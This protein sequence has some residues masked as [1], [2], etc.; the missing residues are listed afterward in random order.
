MCAHL[1]I[2]ETVVVVTTLESGI[3]R[4]FACLDTPEEGFERP[5]YPQDHILQDLSVDRS[6]VLPQL[7]YIWQLGFLLVVANRHLTHLPGIAAF[8]KRGIVEFSAET[9]CGF[10][11]RG[12][13]WRGAQFVLEG[14]VAWSASGIASA[15]PLV[16]VQ[17]TMLFD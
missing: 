16:R 6:A 12:L 8:L 3:A 11:L 7:A 9:K 10:K 5:V 17:Y 13:L 2:G 1:R 4:L 15:A 14:L